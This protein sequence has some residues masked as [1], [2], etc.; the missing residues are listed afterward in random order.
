MLTDDARIQ[1]I[2]MGTP[3]CWMCGVQCPMR[4]L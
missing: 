1:T 4:L 2:N 3:I